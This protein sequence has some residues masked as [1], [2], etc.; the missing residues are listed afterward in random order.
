MKIS[1]S[2]CLYNLVSA[3]K[4]LLTL[5]ARWTSGMTLR[6]INTKIIWQMS[7]KKKQNQVGSPPHVVNDSSPYGS[8]RQTGA[9]GGKHLHLLTFD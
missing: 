5:I 1:M 4:K 3:L 8:V 7:I 2:C 6:E 9:Q